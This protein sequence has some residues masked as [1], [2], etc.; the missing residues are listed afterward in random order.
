MMPLWTF[1]W[2]WIDDDDDDREK[3]VPYICDVYTHRTQL[4]TVN[5][6][7]YTA[8]AHRYQGNH[9]GAQEWHIGIDD[10]STCSFT[11]SIEQKNRAYNDDQ[12]T[13][14]KGG[15][16]FFSLLLFLRFFLIVYLDNDWFTFVTGRFLSPI[17]Q[18]FLIR[19]A[20]ERERG[21]RKRRRRRL[22]CRRNK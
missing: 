16:G 4:F 1:Y 7:V 10:S 22:T 18:H 14:K 8:W 6:L 2:H 12:Q 5:Y 21:E 20:N 13:Q 15:E 9:R 3:S 17:V 11:F 19:I